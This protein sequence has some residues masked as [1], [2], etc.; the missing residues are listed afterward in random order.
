VTEQKPRDAFTCALEALSQKERTAGE[1]GALLAKRGFSLEEIEEAVERLV[2]ARALDDEHFAHR[3][4]EDKRELRGWGPERIEEALLARGLEPA[5]IAAALAGD[6]V[7]GQ[8]ERAIGLL[9]RRGQV[10][11]DQASRTRALAFLAR[12]GYGSELAY[13]AVRGFERSTAA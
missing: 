1:L 12:R 9:E 13:D 6:G 2:A 10:V 8:L 11:D 7:E 5:T 4:A 3:F